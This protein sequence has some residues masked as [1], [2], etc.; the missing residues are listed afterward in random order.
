M[1]NDWS[2][3]PPNLLSPEIVRK[4][5]IALEDGIVCGL[6]AFYCAGCGPEPCA[7]GDLESYLQDVE[8]SR[9]GYWFTLWSVPTLD[10]QNR[11]LIRKQKAAVTQ[12][13]LQRT[14]DWLDADPRH[15][16]IVVGRANSGRAPEVTWG[17][18]DR[19]ERIQD[20][21]DRFAQTGEFAVLSIPDLMEPNDKHDWIP[22][23]HLV[24][25]K[26]PNEHGEVPL[27]GPY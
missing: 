2:A 1:P 15:E 13:E 12:A 8:K 20:F 23:F 27:G 25:A 24:D 3:E 6:H 11:L 21:A 10:V 16:F 9:P 14:K 4:V 22:R 19:F 7:F 18:Y 17:D 5:G 26:R